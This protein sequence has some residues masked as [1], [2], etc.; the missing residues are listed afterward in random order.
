MTMTVQQEVFRLQVSIDNLLRMEVFQ[1]EDHFGRVELSNGIGK[2]LERKGQS[3]RHRFNFKYIYISLAHLRLAQQ[4]KKFTTLHKVHDHIEIPRILPCTPQSDQERVSGA[5][6]HA[7][8]IIGMLDLLH[9]HDL[10]LLEDLQG[11]KAV[12]MLRLGQMDSTETAG[13]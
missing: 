8:L 5:A 4:A 11:V 12:V 9:F 3:N 13:A 7:S 10:G 2:T 6:Q 1:C